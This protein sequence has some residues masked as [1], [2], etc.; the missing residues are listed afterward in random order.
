MPNKKGGSIVEGLWAGTAVFA[1][2]KANTYADFVSKFLLYAVVLLVGLM[3]VAWVLRMVTGR[4]MFV[5]EIKCPP[6][7]S[8]IEKCPGTGTSGCF[9]EGTGNC[10]ALPGGQ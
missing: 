8:F 3:V 7:S 6:G 2:V 4:E 5:S 10:D 1:A 9:Y